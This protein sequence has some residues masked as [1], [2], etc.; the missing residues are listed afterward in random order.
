MECYIIESVIIDNCVVSKIQGDIVRISPIHLLIQQDP[1]IN[2]HLLSKMSY[3]SKENDNR[4]LS[5][6]TSGL[7]KFDH[8]KQ[9]DIRLISP[10]NI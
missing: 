10:F 2:I 6:L 3:G 4:I 9:V 1:F 7:L 5:L 8:L